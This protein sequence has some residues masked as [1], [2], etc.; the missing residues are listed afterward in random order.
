MQT[1][2]VVSEEDWELIHFLF[3]SILYFDLEIELS[4]CNKISISDVAKVTEHKEWSHQEEQDD[5]QTET[6]TKAFLKSD[7]LRS[8]F[9][10]EITL[11]TI[12]EEIEL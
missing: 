1:E 12:L 4:I 6:S 9:S 2:W 10:F 5:S 8:K 3:K 11:V 7:D